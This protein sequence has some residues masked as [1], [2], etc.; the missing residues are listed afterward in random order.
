KP[1]GATAS[2]DYS[3]FTRWRF[4]S[5]VSQRGIREHLNSFGINLAELPIQKRRDRLE[6]IPV[7]APFSYI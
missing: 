7:G 5:K 6:I 3:T 4:V 2:W 1:P